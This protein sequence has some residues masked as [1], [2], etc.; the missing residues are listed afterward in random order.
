[1]HQGLLFKL[2]ELRCPK[3]IAFLNETLLTNRS[4]KIIHDQ[5]RTTTSLTTITHIL[6][7]LLQLPM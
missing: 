7:L 6:R 5:T 2:H 3:Y 1:M 4:L